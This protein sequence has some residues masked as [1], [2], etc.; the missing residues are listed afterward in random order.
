MMRRFASLGG[1]AR[2]PYGDPLASNLPLDVHRDISTERRT[3]GPAILRNSKAMRKW[4]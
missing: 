3:G 2:N 1:A 4:I